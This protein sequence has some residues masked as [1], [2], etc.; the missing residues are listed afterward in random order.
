MKPLPILKL[1]P[2]LLSLFIALL[3]LITI[4][5]VRAAEPGEPPAQV[6]VHLLDYVGVDYGGAVENGKVKSADEY[7]EMTEFSAQI[8]ER[9]SR[10]PPNPRREALAAEATKLATLVKSKAAPEAVAEQ[11]SR[12]KTGL[13]E[14]YVLAVA[15]RK[16]P[17][18]ATG[19]RL[20]AQQCAGCHGVEGRGDGPQSKGLEPAP[21]NFHNVERMSSRSVYGLFNTITLGV[22]GTSMVAYRQLSEADRWALAFHVANLGVAPERIKA[23]EA[24]W[25]S[26]EAR[27]LFRDLR[28]VATLSSNEMKTR[29]GERMAQAQDY[30]RAHPEAIASGKPDPLA[31]TRAQV[32][33]MVVAYEKGDRQDARELA[34]SAYLDGF[35]LIEATL[36]TVD[37]GLREEIEREMMGLRSAVGNAVPAS[38]LEARAKRLGGL[39]DRAEERIGQGG[40]SEAAV[41]TGSLVIL[42]REGME[43]ILILA[44]LVAFVARTGRRDA[45]P[46]LHAGWLAALAL[47]VVT[48]FAATYLIDFSGAGRE[49][50]EGITALVAAVM[51]LYVGY[52]LHGKTQ[53]QQWTQ[54]LR[55]QVDSALEKKTLWAMAGVSFLAVYRELFEVVLFYQAL[56][57]Q[58]GPNGT[59]ALLGGIGAAIVVLAL[60]GWALFRYSVRLP[61]APFFSVM[62]WFVLLI[63]F[64]FA[65]DGVAKLQEAGVIGASQVPFASVPLLGI[66]PTLETL[67]A[68]LAVI[69][70]VAISYFLMREPATAKVVKA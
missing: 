39:L 35:E 61:L 41:F 49:M 36:D 26:D 16:T 31:F 28:N 58:A 1:S 20:Y 32:A 46:W 34:I 37:R 33:Q 59:S 25:K 14:A 17:D 53:S 21:A 30:L 19:A 42:L 45:L 65:G 2:R 23:G 56:W 52:W 27:A 10:L 7:Q 9:I 57:A 38:E 5:P 69:V 13:I 40:L 44:A 8:G 15:P 11:A 18:L 68:Q 64:V 60:V 47:G 43:A 29:H 54:F 67:A 12:I 70:L 24:G 63:A 3:S 48:W 22:T 66:H 51:L 62:L 50:T 4:V 55:A 6:V